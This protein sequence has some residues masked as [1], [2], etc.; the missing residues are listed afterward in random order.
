MNQENPPTQILFA[1]MPEAARRLG[2]GKT[3]LYEQIHTASFCTAT[4]A[5][6]LLWRSG[7]LKRHGVQPLEPRDPPSVNTIPLS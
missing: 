6:G 2:I 1:S 3:L 4:S 5:A 7:C